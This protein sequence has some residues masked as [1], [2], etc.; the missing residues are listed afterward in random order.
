M[1]LVIVI[2]YST[3]SLSEGPVVLE[4]HSL[5]QC[6]CVGF[7]FEKVHQQILN[8]SH[9]NFIENILVLEIYKRAWLLWL[10]RLQRRL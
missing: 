2:Q 4:S 5:Q 1:S 3:N 10:R 9:V 8:L 7:F 6:V